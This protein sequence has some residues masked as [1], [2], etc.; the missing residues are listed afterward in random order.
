MPRYSKVQCVKELRSIW[1]SPAGDLRGQLPSKSARDVPECK[2]TQ[3]LM[4]TYSRGGGPMKDFARLSDG[5]RIVAWRDGDKKDSLILKQIE[6]SS[7]WD[8]DAIIGKAI[9][10]R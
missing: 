3:G 8:L 5:I 6:F 1:L 2:W 10:D 9:S 7:A 4:W